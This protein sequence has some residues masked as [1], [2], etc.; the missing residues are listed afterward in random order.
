MKEDNVTKKYKI[1]NLVFFNLFPIILYIMLNRTIHMKAKYIVIFYFIYNFIFS[2]KTY[3]GNIKQDENDNHILEI[4]TQ[5]AGGNFKIP[6]ELGYRTQK[7]I[8]DY[9][10]KIEDLSQSFCETNYNI[11]QLKTKSE[12]L[13]LDSQ[14]KIRIFV[15]D[16]TGQQIYNSSLDST[17]KE[18]LISNRDRDYFIKAKNTMETQISKPIYSNR[19]NKLSIIIAVPYNKNNK[20]KGIVGT[21]LDLQAISEPKEKME[22]IIKGTISILRDLIGE[23]GST[24]KKLSKMVKDILLFNDEIHNRNEKV[25]ED[26]S[27][28]A[29]QIVDNNYILQDSSQ[30]INFVSEDLS[31]IVSTIEVVEEKINQSAEAMVLT[32]THMEELIDSMGKTKKSSIESEKVVIKLSQKANEINDII[33][34]VSEIARQTNLLALNAS[35][36]AA[37]AGE[38]GQGFAVVAD[39]IKKLAE[40]SNNKVKE[41]ENVLITIKDYLDDVKGQVKEVQDTIIEQEQKLKENQISLSSLIDISKENIKNTR[42]MIDEIKDINRKI[43]SINDSV[44][45]IASGSQETTAMFEEI[46]AQVQEQFNNIEDVG[47]VI[48]EIEIVTGKISKDISKF[49]Y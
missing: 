33:A 32:Q 37:R 25:I 6:T 29:N 16:E 27:I 18:K 43:F 5:M 30:N 17:E 8:E 47:R 2:I 38:K 34:I 35:I 12:K 9:V 46:V 41:I 31:N 24:I 21:T 10:R 45:N 40:D 22:N 44:I 26:I 28:V 14:Y 49:R 4:F 13:I 39:E 3:M 19:E 42:I 23:I 7:N 1:L 36:E 20:F 15:T 48:G 11:S